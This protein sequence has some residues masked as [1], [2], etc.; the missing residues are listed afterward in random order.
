ME[1]VTS[2]TFSNSRIRVKVTNNNACGDDVDGYDYSYS[3][4]VGS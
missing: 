3:I 1:F 4:K 2:E